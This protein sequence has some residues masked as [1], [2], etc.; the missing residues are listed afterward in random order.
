MYS[1]RDQEID[2]IR[3]KIDDL[4]RQ[5]DALS[6][7][8]LPVIPPAVTLFSGTPTAQLHVDQASSTAAVPVL[9]LDQG[10]GDQDF[11]EFVG[12]SGAGS[13]KSIST[14]AIGTYRG[15]LQI[16]VNGAT[17]FVPYYD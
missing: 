3:R 13:A 16:T 12:L 7:R 15:K 14:D 2:D 1:E 9:L 5:L 10:D 8:S 4:R 11:I 17:Y 6:R